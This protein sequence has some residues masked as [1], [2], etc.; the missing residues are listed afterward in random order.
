M[1]IF[2]PTQDGLRV[3]LRVSSGAETDW[4]DPVYEV[5]TTKTQRLKKNHQNHKT[6]ANVNSGVTFKGVH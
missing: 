6:L 3:Y 5:Y 4:T 2:C 1:C